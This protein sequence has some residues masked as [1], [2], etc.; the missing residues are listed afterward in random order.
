MANSRQFN[1]VGEPFI[2]FYKQGLLS[3]DSFLKAQKNFND[4]FESLSHSSLRQ[5]VFVKDMGYHAA[6]FISDSQI[7]SAKHAFLIRNPKLSIPS[8]YKMRNDFHE[9]ETGFEGQYKLF[10][11]ILALTKKSHSL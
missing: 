3:S 2:D 8:L 7:L 11:R 1:V 5:A 9:N 10:K 6:E 4:T